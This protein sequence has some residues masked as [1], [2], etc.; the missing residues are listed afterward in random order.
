MKFVKEILSWILITAYLIVVLGFVSEERK[1][2]P[3]ISV[4]V[5]IIDR[6]N[7]YFVEEDDIIT[8]IYDKGE[9]ML[10]YP[11]DSIN[12]ARLEALI[13]NHP[14]I[15]RAEVYAD[16]HGDLN[17]DI[18]QRNPILRIIN[19]NKESYYIDEEGALMPLS[20][21]FTAHV[22]VANGKINEPYS[23]RY[24]K[25][26][27]TQTEE[28]ELNRG[29]VLRDLFVL[30]KYIYEDEFWR[31][32]FEQIYVNGKSFELIPRVGTHVIL[33]GGIENYKEKLRNLKSVYQ[34]GFKKFGWNNYSTINLKYHN[35]VICTKR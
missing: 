21:K 1:N 33:F 30:A 2:I 4:H 32:Q 22:L 8:A 11:I 31:A 34:I 15:K 7:N 23:L 35:Q 28:D 13:Y 9:K 18:I 16:I 12:L 3:C 24:T 26:I 27:L 14:S 20:N 19:Y 29:E 5:Q 17:I 10:G 6:T 25:D